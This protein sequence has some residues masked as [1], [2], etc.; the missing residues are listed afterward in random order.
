MASRLTVTLDAGPAVHQNAGLARYTERLAAYLLR[1]H[2]DEIDLTLFY[3]A[4]SGDTLPVTLEDAPVHTIRR[5]QYAWRLGA[6]A[7]QLLRLSL[8]R[9][10]LSRPSGGSSPSAHLYHATEHLLPYL[11]TPTVLTVHDLIFER[12]PQHHTRRNRWFLRWA[13]PRFVRAADA[14]IAVSQQTRRDLITL[15]QT[16]PEKIHVVYEGIDPEFAPAPDAERARVRAQYSP[17]RPFLLMVG[18]LEPRKNH[19]AALRALLRL[20][21]AGYPHRLVIA[22]GQGWL[23]EPIRARVEAMGLTADV[24]FT[25]FVPAADLPP[26]YS[27]ADC[28]LL[29]SL[30]EGFGFTALEAMACGTA[31]ICSNVGSLPEVTGNAALTVEPR[32]DAALAAAVRRVLDAP[33]LAADLRE[34]GL[35]RARQ[36][37]WERCA[38]E[39]AAVYRETA[40]RARYRTVQMRERGTREKHPRSS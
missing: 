2:A 39:T 7:S 37:R 11:R 35:A 21:R 22:G 32:D 9:N 28:V 10:V 1:N 16:P 5:G 25:G 36:F 8:H 12:Y 24:H 26:L 14:I 38:V 13:M 33:D 20:K 29:P 30:Y 4:H 6:L 15:Y 40:S 19:L 3:N 17:D 31:V 23:F 18:T 34:R 27:A